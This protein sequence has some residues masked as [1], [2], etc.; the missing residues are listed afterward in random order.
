MELEFT[1]DEFTFMKMKDLNYA[2]IILIIIHNVYY[3]FS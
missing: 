1:L 2:A 3:F